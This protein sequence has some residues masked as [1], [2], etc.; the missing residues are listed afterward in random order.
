LNYIHNHDDYAT[1]PVRGL[2]AVLPRGE[3][4]LWQ[5]A[6]SWRALARQV[7]HTR[8]IAVL[9]GIA[10]M[11]RF[12]FA[13]SGGATPGTALGEAGIILAFGAVGIGILMLLAWLVER[14]TVYTITNKRIVMRI[15]VAIQKTFNV[16]FATIDGAALRAD[17]RDTGSLSVSLKPGVS[18]AYL[19]LWPHV[20][21]WRISHTEPTFRA[22][23]K[24][25]AVARLL[26]DAFT[27]HV[28]TTDALKQSGSRPVPL[29]AD[30]LV[31]QI[32]GS[33]DTETDH[34]EK[35]R[36]PHYIPR[37]L[38][39]MAASAAIIT[40]L[41]VAF[42]QWTNAPGLRGNEGAP[43]FSQE[44]QF[45]ALEGDRIA[46]EDASDGVLIT[47]IEAGTD[48]LLRSALRG[49]GMTR[50][51]SELDLAAPYVLERFEGDG[52][53]LSDGLTGRSIRLESFGPIETGATADLLR[54]GHSGGT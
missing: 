17:G 50:S 35:P 43:V 40:V 16:P 6:P 54:L 48:G 53:Y 33:S 46:V 1:E 5:G 49:L 52:V 14:T 38:A 13:L 23:P 3:F 30:S 42:A 10:A 15:G 29:A 12:G 2:P 25:S 31:E 19:I 39:M 22:I 18:L 34:D 51:M 7:F 27:S 4:V 21:P 24:A 20:R 28:Q 9:V 47:T 41:V 11:A 44:I 32:D 26:T 36:D 8:A 45:L 37:P